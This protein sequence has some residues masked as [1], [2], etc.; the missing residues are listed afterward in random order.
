MKLKKQKQIEFLKKT[1]LI[2]GGEHFKTRKGRDHARPITTQE[3]MHFS[4]RSTKATGD[5]SFLKHKQ[6]IE[7][8]LEK[9]ARKNGVILISFAN[10]G[11]HLHLTLRLTSRHTYR[12]FI[13]AI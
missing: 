7:Q 11:N 2:Y 6:K 10:V 13:R 8:I 3:T 5:W 12:A 1:K 4:L 9:F